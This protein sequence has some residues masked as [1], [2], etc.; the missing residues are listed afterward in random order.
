MRFEMLNTPAKR[1]S[2]V[3]PAK[4]SCGCAVPD[5]SATDDE[6]LTPPYITGYIKTNSGEV[7]VVSVILSSRDKWETVKARASS[8]RMSY[9]VKPGLYAAGNPDDNSD[10]F[11]TANYKMSFDALRSAL[12]GMNAWI[13]VLDTNGI[14]VWCAAGKGTFGTNELLKRILYSK[15]DKKVAHRKIIVPQLGAPGVD[16]GEVKRKSGFSVL[17]G[18]VRA[19]DLNRY[20]QNGYKCDE[21]MRRVR[22]DIIDRM[23]LTPIELRQIFAK[24]HLFLIFV[25]IFFGLVPQ[26]IIFRDSIFKGYPFIAAGLLAIFSGAFFT[27]VFLPF[28]PFRAFALKG[29]I[30]GFAIFA[31]A[32]YFT[33]IF[34]TYNIYLITSAMILFPLL[35][36]YM[37]LQF[38]GASTYTSLSGVKRELKI[39]FPVYISGAVLSF[40]FLI[41][42]KISDWGML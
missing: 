31:A 29:W 22:F 3:V 28:I 38:T 24:F 32:V 39:A 36:S 30:S 23:I 37:A 26:G 11:V 10:V 2:P 25:L 33:G 21:A 42:Y 18:P 17:Y 35:S 5:N 12:N 4:P 8:F 7:P 19:E 13:L 14:N 6:V 15:L 34:E 41:F 9:S 40:V 20:V 16:S 1:I 27:P